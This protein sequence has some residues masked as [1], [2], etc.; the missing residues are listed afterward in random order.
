MNNYKQEIRKDF[1]QGMEIH[2]IIQKYNKATKSLEQFNRCL[3]WIGDEQK[4]HQ[5]PCYWTIKKKSA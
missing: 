1:A 5:A 4:Y 3:E 2:Q